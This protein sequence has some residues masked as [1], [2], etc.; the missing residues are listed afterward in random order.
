MSVI[1]TM[2]KDLDRRQQTS[3][4]DE[5]PVPELQYQQVSA[6][7]LPW[8]LLIFALGVLLLGGFFGWRKL[9]LL[10]QDN[11]QMS[12]QF[13]QSLA[14]DVSQ[15][16]ER[17]L[18]STASDENQSATTTEAIVDPAPQQ[19]EIQTLATAASA[20]HLTVATEDKSDET[21]I[22]PKPLIKKQSQP[23]SQ[24][25]HQVESVAQQVKQSQPDSEVSHSTVSAR[26]SLTSK[27]D[28]NNQQNSKANTGAMAVT[29][30]KLSNEALAQKRFDAGKALQA[31]GQMQ[32]AQQ[33]FTAAIKLNPALHQARQH[34]AALYYGQQ[35]LSQ[36]ESLL[37]QGLTLY[38]QEYDYALLLARV[39]QSAGLNDKALQSLKLIPDTH[40]LAVQKWTMESYLAQQTQQFSLAEQSYRQLARV[41]PEQAKWW[42]GL[43]YALDSQSKYS[44]AKQAYQQALMQKGLSSQASAFIEERLT[45]LGDIE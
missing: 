19:V 17:A 27:A 12:Q 10:Q 32:Q 43:A 11:Q 14:Q 35:M 30:V 18:K 3:V 37:S 9:T 22:S 5:L 20:E 4:A 29:E 23:Q 1:N 21:V 24:K 26:S 45:Q 13:A 15:A 36:A 33:S 16:S 25:K 31:E 39:Y 40:R 34:L 8:I 44:A 42:M 41:E 28:V 2:L 38:P 6:S 7:K